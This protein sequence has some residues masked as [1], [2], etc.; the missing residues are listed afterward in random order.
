[1]CAE[2]LTPSEVRRALAAIQKGH[3]LGA[4]QLTHEDL[5]RAR[6]ILTRE[7]TPEAARTELDAALKALVDDERAN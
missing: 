4:H 5:D 7:L 2:P 1:M 3:E 6:R